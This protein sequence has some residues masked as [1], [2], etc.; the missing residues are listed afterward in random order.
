MKYLF[1]FSLVATAGL[2]LSGEASARCKLNTDKSVTYVQTRGGM[3]GSRQDYYRWDAG[4][5]L[6]CTLISTGYHREGQDCWIEYNPVSGCRKPNGGYTIK[7][8][9]FPK[10]FSRR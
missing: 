10:V 2:I 8:R 4:G 9:P 5:G 3:A 1:T 7:M 6:Q